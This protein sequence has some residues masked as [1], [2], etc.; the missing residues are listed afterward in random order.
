[1]ACRAPQSG[2]LRPWATSSTTLY[3]D[4]MYDSKGPPQQL[5]GYSTLTQD[6]FAWCSF[7]IS[8]SPCS[9]PSDFHPW[10]SLSTTAKCA[11]RLHFEGRTLGSTYLWCKSQCHT[12]SYTT[13]Q[14]LWSPN[15]TGFFT[16]WQDNSSYYGSI[17]IPRINWIYMNLQHWGTSAAWYKMRPTPQW[18]LHWYKHL[19]T[20]LFRFQ[21][22]GLSLGLYLLNTKE[23]LEQKH[24]CVAPKGCTEHSSGSC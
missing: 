13:G 15:L 12:G 6:L 17:L 9:L 16:P 23:C 4:S 8:F 1:M 5:L 2:W 22:Q 20:D 24:I 18:W 11:L 3:S 10:H 19:I 7:C 14:A 21:V